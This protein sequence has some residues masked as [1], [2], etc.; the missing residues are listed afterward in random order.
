MHVMYTRAPAVAH[1]CSWTL[2]SYKALHCEMLLDGLSKNLK[3]AQA[4]C[5][6]PHGSF[7]QGA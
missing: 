1:G 2:K 4:P 5:Q 3:A 6:D 7:G